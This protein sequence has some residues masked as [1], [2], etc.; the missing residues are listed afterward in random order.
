[1]DG[2]IQSCAA[3]FE[4]GVCRAE[5]GLERCVVGGVEVWGEFGALDIAGA[6]VD[7]KGRFK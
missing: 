4:E 3:I 1:M 5:I 6:A 7:D 2:S